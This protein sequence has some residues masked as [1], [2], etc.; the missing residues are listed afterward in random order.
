MQAMF[1]Q[2]SCHK[3]SKEAYVSIFGQLE[4]LVDGHVVFGSPDVVV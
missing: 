2:E 1:K 3:G 4:S